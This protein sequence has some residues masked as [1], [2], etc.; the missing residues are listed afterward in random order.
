MH[1]LRFSILSFILIFSN[2]HNVKGQGFINTESFV[3][4]NKNSLKSSYDY[5]NDANNNGFISE[6]ELRTSTDE[7]LLNRQQYQ[8]RVTP[9]NFKKQKIEKEIVS[10]L[11]EEIKENQKIWERNNLKNILIDWVSIYEHRESLIYKDS[12]LATYKDL[13][14]IISEKLTEGSL[15]YVPLIEIEKKIYEIKNSIYLSEKKLKILYTSYFIS[16]NSTLIFD[17]LP[18]IKEIKDFLQSKN[19][20]FYTL[21]PNKKMEI[22]NELLNKEIGLEKAER[23]YHF[24]FL[25]LEYQ[26]PHD[27][28]WQKN[29]AVGV[30]MNIPLNKNQF[31]IKELEIEKLAKK[32]KIELDNIN[33]LET[34]RFERD[35]LEEKVASYEIFEAFLEASNTAYQKISVVPTS[36]EG[37]LSQ[38]LKVKEQLLKTKLDNVERRSS[39]LRDY[40]TVSNKNGQLSKTYFIKTE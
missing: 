10:L 7:F 23:K 12:L 36:I 38:I 14:V 18:K 16:N 5:D 27:R 30:S 4:K 35:I 26:G 37:E 17:D 39:I 1:Y 2:L 11:G 24:N 25:Q 8:I 28:D 32:Q 9:V 31:K 6:I 15:A 22:K 29:I 20:D 40:F 34:I 33:Y 21:P 19:S 3:K 13:K